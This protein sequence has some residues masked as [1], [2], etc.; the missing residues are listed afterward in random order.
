M[1]RIVSAAQTRGAEPFSYKRDDGYLDTDYA[2]VRLRLR[3]AS[4]EVNERKDRY[5]VYNSSL[6]PTLLRAIQPI[7]GI[8]QSRT[9]SWRIPCP[10]ARL[11]PEWDTDMTTR[12][13]PA[14]YESFSVYAGILCPHPSFRF[15]L[16]GPGLFPNIHQVREH[17]RPATEDSWS[18][19][20]S[21][22]SV[23]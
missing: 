17:D 11:D 8:S 9:D 3:H 2:S 7:F 13:L 1:Y 12:L 20:E 21:D 14:G 19:Y 5:N 10:G 6:F 23:H 22:I 16:L 15:A 4:L 18:V